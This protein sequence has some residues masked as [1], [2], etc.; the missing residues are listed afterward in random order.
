MTGRTQ[1]SL[2]RWVT[3]RSVAFTNSLGN[4]AAIAPCRLLASL[5]AVLPPA[6]PTWTDPLAAARV[7]AIG[8]R[9]GRLAL[10]GR[11]G[12]Y[13]LPSPT[14]AKGFDATL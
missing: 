8:V 5:I 14:P 4:K 9:T 3:D 10:M 13:P 11:L 2:C 12:G 1:L 7:P 6:V